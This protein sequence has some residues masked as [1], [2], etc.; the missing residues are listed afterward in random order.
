MTRLLVG[1]DSAWTA[2]NS[3]GFVGVLH[4]HIGGL[5][6]LGPPIAV[7]LLP[8][9]G[10]MPIGSDLG[11]HRVEFSLSLKVATGDT[12]RPYGQPWRTIAGRDWL[13]IFRD[14]PRFPPSRQRRL[15]SM[16]NI[17][18]AKSAGITIR[19][20]PANTKVLI[21]GDH[22]TVR[23]RCTRALCAVRTAGLIPRPAPSPHPSLI[24]SCVALSSLY[25]HHHHLR[26]H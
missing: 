19:Y 11:P 20:C 16:L 13:G 10:S 6:E 15:L 12:A 3:G 2:G 18:R 17:R 9:L 23:T 14:R 26:R 8:M 5:S 22:E 1:F 7:P 24:G 21:A 4:T 25:N